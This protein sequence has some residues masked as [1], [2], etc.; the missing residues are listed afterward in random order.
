MVRRGGGGKEKEQIGRE[1]MLRLL[2]QRTARTKEQAKKTTRDKVGSSCSVI[3]EGGVFFCFG[4]RIARKK[5]K[6]R[7]YDGKCGLT[8][9]TVHAKQKRRRVEVL[10]YNSSNVGSANG[11]EKT[12]KREEVPLRSKR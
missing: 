5:K 7:T 10:R 4:A 2:S 1:T 8:L 11:R 12:F 9:S 3:G 6:K